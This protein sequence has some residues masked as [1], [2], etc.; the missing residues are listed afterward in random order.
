MYE[1]KITDIRNMM[2][3]ELRFLRSDTGEKPG[4]VTV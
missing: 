3:Q 4:I 2:L 1:F